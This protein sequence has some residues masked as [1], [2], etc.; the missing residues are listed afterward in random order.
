MGG[1]DSH[2]VLGGE[3]QG[4]GTQ[5]IPVPDPHLEMGG[6]GG[7]AL[8]PPKYFFR[9]P[10]RPPPPPPLPG[11]LPWIRHCILS[12]A[13]APAPDTHVTAEAMFIT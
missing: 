9:P 12:I 11:P 10:P 6:G 1:T 13:P 2:S 5:D 4:H 8:V 3:S 7:G